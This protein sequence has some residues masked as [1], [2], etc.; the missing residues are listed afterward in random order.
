[1]RL[2][3]PLLLACGFTAATKV[4][5]ADTAVPDT[6]LGGDDGADDGGSD[7]GGSDGGGDDGG[8]EDPNDVDD[9]QDG[10]TENEG[11]CDDTDPSIRPGQVDGCDGIDNDCDGD[12][13]EDAADSDPREPDDL[14]PNDLG[15]L[16]DDPEH[17]IE[18]SLT[19]NDDVDRYTFSLEDGGLSLFHVDVGLSNIPDDATYRLV[20]SNTSTGEVMYDESGSGSL[21]ASF[22]DRI[23]N[24]ESGTWE[25]TISARGGADCARRYLLSISYRD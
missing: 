16:T 12:T 4:D 8:D 18:A 11:D 17:A 20:V 19:D 15:A 1:M 3:L 5:S 13:D 2:L 24:D 7:D 22:D 9:D 23:F 21:A 10:L 6:G 14:D 25:A